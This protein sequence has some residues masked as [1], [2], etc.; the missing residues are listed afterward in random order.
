MPKMKLMPFW[1][2]VGGVISLM[3][4]TVSLAFSLE[5]SAID[6]MVADSAQQTI[7]IH[8]DSPNEM[9]ARAQL[10]RVKFDD[11]GKILELEDLSTEEKNSISTNTEDFAVAPFSEWPILIEFKEFSAVTNPGVYALVV[12]DVSK[13][14]PLEVRTAI[15][16]LL[17]VSQPE[18]YEANLK[19]S[20]FEVFKL[21]NEWRSRV[22]LENKGR[23]AEKPRALL[24]VTNPLGK[25]VESYSIQAIN[26]RVIPGASREYSFIWP[27]QIL[28]S[29]FA[30]GPYEA[31]FS[32]LG[33]NGQTIDSKTIV[34]WR[35]SW[36]IGFLGLAVGGLLLWLLIKRKRFV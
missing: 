29:W 36:L 1:I 34:I 32:L 16:A 19:V 4:T 21:D 7:S 30:V 10:K 13:S 14:S 23:G 15:T 18:G 20:Q 31:K 17:F 35:F 5:P 11:R 8:N 28:N 3:F 24:S 12:S 22:L 2:L 27:T 6:L 33:E 26:E 9:M 25:E